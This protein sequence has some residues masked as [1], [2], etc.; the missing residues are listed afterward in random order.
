MQVLTRER[1][2]AISTGLRNRISA[3]A[4]VSAGLSG[5]PEEGVA[6]DAVVR[7]DAQEAKIAA[8]RNILRARRIPGR[9]NIVPGKQ[10]QF[11]VIDLHL[12]LARS[13]L[14]NFGRP[15]TVG[16]TPR[17]S[18]TAPCTDGSETSPS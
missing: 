4:S 14:V 17:L 11:D 2:L 15:S 16:A 8:A 7:C 3:P 9:R 13:A 10:S 18:R 5:R 12:V 1:V 6:L